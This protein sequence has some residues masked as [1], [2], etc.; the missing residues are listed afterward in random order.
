MTTQNINI[1]KTTNTEN[2]DTCKVVHKICRVVV[3][4]NVFNDINPIDI[5]TIIYH[6]ETPKEFASAMSW[7]VL[8]IIKN[9]VKLVIPIINVQN[10][11]YMLDNKLIFCLNSLA[12]FTNSSSSIINPFPVA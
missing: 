3:H 4:P 9:I 7:R 12:A 11:I 8:Y 6:F 2:V 10:G 5:P 1:L